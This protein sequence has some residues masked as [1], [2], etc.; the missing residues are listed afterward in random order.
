M[1]DEL[2]ALRA[3][4][5][6]TGVLVLTPALES[7]RLPQLQQQRQAPPAA[8]PPAWQTEKR[9]LVAKVATLEARVKTHVES[10]GL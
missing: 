4:T 5:H 10:G 1:Q 9:V 6:A 3:G 8:P 7:P 2:A